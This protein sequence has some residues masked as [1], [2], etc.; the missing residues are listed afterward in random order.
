MLLEKRKE[1]NLGYGPQRI[2][3]LRF[4]YEVKGGVI[5]CHAFIQYSASRD[6][7]FERGIFSQEYVVFLRSDKTG[8]RGGIS[9]Y[10]F[11]YN[12]FMMRLDSLSIRGRRL[13]SSSLPEMATICPLKWPL[14]V[15]C[16]GQNGIN[17]A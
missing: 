4:F 10:D 5:E 2:F 8:T 9:L 11:K 13:D 12:K 3:S 16:E 17:R 15:E 1:R 14:L 7:Y 6:L